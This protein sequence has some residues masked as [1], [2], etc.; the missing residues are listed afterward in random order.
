MLLRH[1]Q[2]VLE[3]ES[4]SCLHLSLETEDL[5]FDYDQSPA[6]TLQGRVQS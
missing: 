4:D 3:T 2:T 6:R 5:R 1:H